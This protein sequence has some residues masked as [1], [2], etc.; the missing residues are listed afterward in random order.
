[1]E[2]TL[3]FEMYDRHGEDRMDAYCAERTSDGGWQLEND[4]KD[5]AHPNEHVAYWCLSLVPWANED[6]IARAAGAMD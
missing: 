4:D 6:M 1:D 5:H 3:W 2:D